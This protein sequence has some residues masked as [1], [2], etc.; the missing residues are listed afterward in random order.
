MKVSELI[1]K[2][3]EA[4]EKSGDLEVKAFSNQKYTG[5]GNYTVEGDYFP[6][7]MVVLLTVQQ[8]IL[9]YGNGKEQFIGLTL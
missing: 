4:Q 1:K 2:L 3:Q 9:L 8:D 6:I 7:N 5:N